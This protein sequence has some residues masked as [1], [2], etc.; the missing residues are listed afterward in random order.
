[1]NLE[2]IEIEKKATLKNRSQVKKKLEQLGAK[3]KE[4]IIYK[5]DIYLTTDKNPSY[6][7]LQQ[8][9]TV[10]RI[11][12]TLDTYTLTFK[13]RTLVGNTEVNQELEV[14]ILPQYERDLRDFF[15]KIKSSCDN[16]CLTS[17]YLLKN[18]IDIINF[19]QKKNFFLL[20]QK[21]KQ[22]EQ[23]TI[24]Y[25]NTSLTI[26]LNTIVN[27]GDFLEVE[28]VSPLGGDKK[29]LVQTID[30]FFKD[31]GIPKHLEEKRLY[32]ELLLSKEKSSK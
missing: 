25:Q 12:R 14:P 22:T 3:F 20:V 16:E 21:E 2:V 23:A 29:A 32:L 11:R 24:L 8:K 5:N 18:D 31:V 9:N 4:G 19:F 7:G 30:N 10:F 17:L 15:T 26:E 13:Y 27:L 1:M 6:E 28:T